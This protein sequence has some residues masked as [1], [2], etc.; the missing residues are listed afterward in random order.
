MLLNV[1]R[2]G[3]FF[4]LGVILGAHESKLFEIKAVILSILSMGGIYQ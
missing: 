2:L 4:V 1:A 3:S